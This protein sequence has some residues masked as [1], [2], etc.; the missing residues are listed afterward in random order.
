[1]RRSARCTVFRLM[2]VHPNGSVNVT[3]PTPKFEAPGSCHA[4]CP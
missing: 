4:R 2:M 1:M 3:V